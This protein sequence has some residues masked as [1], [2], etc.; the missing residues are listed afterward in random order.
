MLGRVNFGSTPGGSCQR[1]ANGSKLAFN[2]MKSG[3]GGSILTQSLQWLDL[4]SL[5]NVN[6]P[7]P[8][9]TNIGTLSWSPTEEKLAFFGCRDHNVDCGLYRFDPASGKVEQLVPEVFSSW[10]VIWK[11][12]GSQMAFVDTVKQEKLVI[13]VDFSTGRVV[14]QGTFDA[15]AW[16]TPDDSPTNQWGVSFPRGQEGNACFELK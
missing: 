7:A 5:Q 1:S 2:F 9:I 3:P 12:D 13:V 4:R 14:Y 15:N 8:A 11:P 6:T 16:Q 10:P